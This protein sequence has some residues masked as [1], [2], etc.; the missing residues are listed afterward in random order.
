MLAE[1]IHPKT[2][3]VMKKL[4]LIATLLAVGS[5]ALFTGFKSSAGHEFTNGGKTKIAAKPQYFDQPVDYNLAM[6][7]VLMYQHVY[8][9]AANVDSI[10]KAYS[11][12]AD[13]GSQNLSSWAAD[14]AANTNAVTTKMCFGIYTQA[15]ATAY[16]GIVV[17]RL[18]VILFP[19][20]ANGKRAVYTKASTFK[21]QTPA[22]QKAAPAGGGAGTPTNPYNFAGIE[23]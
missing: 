9:N 17:G 5:L 7:C 12:S 4:F 16:P 22:G 6:A 21:I 23:P 3:T 19:V 10:K 2:L 8:A 14:I 1:L 18:T 13:F 20:D 15:M 11:T